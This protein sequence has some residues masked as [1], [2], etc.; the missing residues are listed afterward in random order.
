MKHRTWIGGVCL[1]AV[2]TGAPP[3]SASA[4]SAAPA[5]SPQIS[6]EQT[7]RD[8]TSTDTGVRARAARSLKENP[9]PEAAVPLA[10]AVLD[11][12]DSVQVE[13]IAAELN[14]FLAEPVV[15]RKRVGFV[16]EKRSTIAAEAAFSAGAAAL[17]AR[18]VPIDVLQ[19]LRTAARDDNPRVGLEALYAFGAL[20]IRAAGGERHEVVRAAGP[21]LAAM[22]GAADPAFRYGAL[23]V[24]AHVLEKRRGD[25]PIEP[26]VGDAAIT[27]LNDQDR[28]IRAAAAEALGAM[29]YVRGVQALTELYTFYGRSADAEPLLAALARIAHSSSAAT[30]DAALSS[31]RGE[32]RVLAAEGLARLGDRSKEAAIASALAGERG[33]GAQ[34]AAQFAAAMLGSG[35]LEPMAAALAQP[36]LAERARTYLADLF[37][38]RSAEFARFLQD[39]DARVRA[40]VLDA[41]ARTDDPAALAVAEPLVKDG[42]ALV[43]QAAGRA[44]ARL[45]P[46]P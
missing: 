18:P 7:I 34:L 40:G 15:P 46:A 22:T 26:G 2:V 9:Y 16:I 13:A 14:I 12:D 25:D 1:C 31:G 41:L 44:V 45:R 43:S 20:G 5:P 21:D 3:V 27:A 35:S 11:A 30:F 10:K 32:R 37:A 38:S 42:D 8:L 28:A 33:E 39:P 4:R 17:G 6:F 24:M 29:R 19:A 36:R 23:R